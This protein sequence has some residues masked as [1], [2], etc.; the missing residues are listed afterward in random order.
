LASWLFSQ[1]VLSYVILFVFGGA[2]G[3][4]AFGYALGKS[5]K[6]IRNVIDIKTN[7]A[8]AKTENDE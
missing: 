5:R 3:S 7:I 8:D 1:R 6:Y 2:I 4:W